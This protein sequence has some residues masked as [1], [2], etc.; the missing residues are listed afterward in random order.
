[1]HVQNIKLCNMESLN[2]HNF[3]CKS[4][5]EILKSVYWKSRN[6]CNFLQANITRERERELYKSLFTIASIS[7]IAFDPCPITIYSVI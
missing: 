4:L 3:V 7:R 6:Q 2:C 1:M 5:N